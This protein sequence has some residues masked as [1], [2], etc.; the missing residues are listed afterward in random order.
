MRIVLTSIEQNNQT[1]FL[2]FGK[3]LQGRPGLSSYDLWL[4]DG[5][6]GS[7]ADYYR[8]LQQPAIDA[9]NVLF[10]PDMYNITTQKPLPQGSY[11]SFTDA[12][13]D[14]FI[15]NHVPVTLRKDGI[16]V[17]AKTSE[18]EW[19]ACQ[20]RGDAA[21]DFTKKSAWSK[22]FPIT[23]ADVAHLLVLPL[24]MEIDTQGDS[25]LAWGE[26]MD[27]TCRV[28]R[29]FEDVTDHVATWKVVRNTGNEVEDTAWLLKS[30]VLNFS[31][32]LRISH[33][34]AEN[35]LAADGS[36]STLFLFNA[37]MDDGFMAQYELII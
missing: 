13:S 26:T 36:I 35:D 20:F 32:T 23:E 11:Y 24:R 7:L 5:N 19:I 25:F 30:K 21:T 33:S 15:P 22:I 4:Q 3:V 29:G 14:F 31:G 17:V 10:S 34:L 27:I 37:T 18:T 9:A 2:E 6:T 8:F 16:M 28:F 1:V 12:G